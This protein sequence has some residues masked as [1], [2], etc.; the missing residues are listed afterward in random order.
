MSRYSRR[1]RSDLMASMNAQSCA[2]VQAWPAVAACRRRWWVSLAVG[3]N[4]TSLR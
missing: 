3:R 2:E 1:G 4:L